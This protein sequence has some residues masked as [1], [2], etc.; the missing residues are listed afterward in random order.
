MKNLKDR[1]CA[2]N[3]RHESGE[4]VSEG[5]PVGFHIDHKWRQIVYKEH[6]WKNSRGL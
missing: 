6:S 5:H 2:A 3:D 4:D 1:K